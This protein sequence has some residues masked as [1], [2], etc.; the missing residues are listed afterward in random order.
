[1]IEND[2]K[3]RPSVHAITNHPIFWSKDRQL[4]FFMDVSDRIEKEEETSPVM[5]HLENDANLV[6]K[7]N[8]I[9]HICPYLKEGKPEFTEIIYFAI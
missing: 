3:N 9:E 7:G 2:P 8:W 5:K 6:V 1:M 4:Q